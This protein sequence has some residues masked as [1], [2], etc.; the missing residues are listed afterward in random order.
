MTSIARVIPPVVVL[1]IHCRNSYP[2]DGVKCTLA[3][4]ILLAAQFLMA[5]KPW[6]ALS[7]TGCLHKVGVAVNV[8]GLNMIA[9]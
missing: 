1:E 4:P 7:R 8:K 5:G 9:T 3:G 2:I 6:T